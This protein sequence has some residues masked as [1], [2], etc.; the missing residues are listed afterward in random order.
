MPNARRNGC[1]R[2][3][4]DRD[5]HFRNAPRAVRPLRRIALERADMSFIIEAG[6]VVVRLRPEVPRIE[7]RPLGV[8]REEWRPPP[9]TEI[10]DQRR[11]EDGFPRPRE[12]GHLEAEIG[13]DQIWR[14]NTR[15]RST[16]SR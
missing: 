16:T 11:N 4:R 12:A 6:D 2:P 10:A 1:V 14:L 5:A 9:D 15:R 3:E 8:G 7:S 13:R